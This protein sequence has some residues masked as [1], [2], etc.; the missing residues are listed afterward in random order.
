MHRLSSMIL[1][2]VVGS[3][4]VVSKRLPGYLKDLQV[5]DCLGEL[6]TSF[7]FFF[8]H[9]WLEFYRLAQFHITTPQRVIRVMH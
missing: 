9:M 6:Q 7:F 1:P 5:T 3:L 8:L 2:V 4:G